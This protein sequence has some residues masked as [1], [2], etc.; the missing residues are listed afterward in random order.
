LCARHKRGESFARSIAKLR[1][2]VY[3]AC[4][5]TAVR[6]VLPRRHSA[7]LARIRAVHPRHKSCCPPPG[8][9]AKTAERAAEPASRQSGAA[10]VGAV[11]ESEGGGLGLLSE[12]SLARGGAARPAAAVSPQLVD[13]MVQQVE[14]LAGLG[15]PRESFLSGLAP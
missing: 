6:N 13:A 9:M 12:S 14:V 3:R 10:H 7:A 4:T 8:A 1:P 2:A 11:G 5:C 15:V